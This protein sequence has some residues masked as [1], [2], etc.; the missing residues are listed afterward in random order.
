MKLAKSSDAETARVHTV[1]A[2]SACHGDSSTIR[3]GS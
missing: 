3:S 2:A 1:Q